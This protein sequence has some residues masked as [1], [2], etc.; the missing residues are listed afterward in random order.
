M[1]GGFEDRKK[2]FENKWAHDE[3]LR[4]KVMARRAR[5]FGLWAAGE[6]GISGAAAEAYA[7]E[8]AAADMAEAGDEDIFRKVK[9]DFAGKGVARSDY[10]I[11][12]TMDELLAAAKDQ[13]MHEVK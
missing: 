4:F 1:N 9:E 2:A 5:L 10:L 6:M 7:R 12:K 11:R 8:V 13:V 3:A